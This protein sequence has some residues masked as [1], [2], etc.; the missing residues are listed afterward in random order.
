MLSLPDF[1][2]KQIL[3]I[4][5]D[6]PDLERDSIFSKDAI[7]GLKSLKEISFLNEN[8]T[9]KKEGKI[10]QQVPFHKI[11]SIFVVGNCTLTN[12]F[13]KSV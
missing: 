8:L 13:I 11:F 7:S 10:V 3:F 1:R 12:V 5:L 4:G 9:I 2:E 6:L